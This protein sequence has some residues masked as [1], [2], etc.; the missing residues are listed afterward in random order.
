MTQRIRLVLAGLV[1]MLLAAGCT[2]AP[3]VSRSPAPAGVSPQTSEAT[4]AP[5]PSGID[6]SERKKAA[7]IADCPQSDA[8]VEVRKDG[9]PGAVLPCLGGGRPVRLAGLRGTPMLINVWAQWCTPCRAEAPFL[10][11]VAE[12]EHPGLLIL[13]IDHADPRPDRAI[14][15]ARF[16]HWAYP[17]IADPDLVLRD[18]LQVVGPPQTF[19]VRADGSIAY[20]HVG[21]FTSADQ[22]RQLTAQHLGVRL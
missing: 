1:L 22:I 16:A 15:F 17:Q 18:S 13:G 9:L 10:A 2:E 4:A 19:F 7:G 14:E 3:A 21:P 12:R 20:R 11:E 6:L 8:H 5:A